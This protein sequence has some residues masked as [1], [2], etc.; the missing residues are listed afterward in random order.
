MNSADFLTAEEKRDVV[1]LPPSP[2]APTEADR[3]NK[4]G[5]YELKLNPWHDTQNGQFTHEGQGARF[6]VSGGNFANNGTP[7]TK[8]FGGSGGG[9]S[10]GGGASGSWDNP[11][12]K[13]KL[14]PAPPKR[15]KIR[16]RA[17][18]S[19][20]PVIQMPGKPATRKVKANGYH[21]ELDEQDRTVRAWGELRLDSAQDRAPHRQRDEGKPDRLQTDHGGHFIGKQF[22]GPKEAIN[23][24]AQDANFNQSDYAKLENLWR[25]K[26]KEKKRVQVDIQAYYA[27]NSKRPDL[28]VVAYWVDGKRTHKRFP[29]KSGRTA[30]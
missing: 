6:G 23:L 15:E 30:K 11:K 12:P 10:G 28:I 17:S 20:K 4:A 9:Q 18:S 26:L 2:A 24:F 25:G 27:G 16:P 22:G 14:I 29:N 5:I 1:G 3:E 7:K 19:A 8:P 21:F 13:L